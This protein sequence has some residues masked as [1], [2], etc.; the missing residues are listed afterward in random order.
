MFDLSV[1][2]VG[3]RW[4]L[5]DDVDGEIGAD[6]R[7]AE[8]LSAASAYAVLDGEPR[9]VLIHEAGGGW[10]EAVVAPPPVH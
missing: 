9:H 4:L 2:A 1:E 5:M 7:K 8:A 6:G 10:G 3:G